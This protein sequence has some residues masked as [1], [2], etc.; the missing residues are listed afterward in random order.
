MAIDGLVDITKMQ[1]NQP[2]EAI[3][4]A[5]VVAQTTPLPPIQPAQQNPAPTDGPTPVVPAPGA[6]DLPST[7]TPNDKTTPAG[8]QQEPGTEKKPASPAGDPATVDPPAEVPVT[9]AVPAGVVDPV[10]GSETPEQYKTRLTAEAAVNAK[11]AAEAEFLKRF[12]VESVEELDNKVNTPAALTDEQKKR[13]TDLHRNEVMNYAVKE[14]AYSPDD[15]TKINRLEQMSDNDLVFERFNQQWLIDNKENPLFT[16]KDL[17]AEARYEFESLF[18]LKAENER[19]RQTGEQSLKLTAD[20]IRNEAKGMWEAAELGYQNYQQ[21]R[22]DVSQFKKEVQTSINTSLPKEMEFKLAD[23]NTAKFQ[24]DKID[25]KGLE[26][27]LRK[28]PNFDAFIKAGKKD[29][30]PFLNSKIQ[31]YIAINHYKDMIATV[32]KTSHD[33]GFNKGTAGARAPFTTTQPQPVT[34]STS[35]LSAAEMQKIADITRLR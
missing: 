15:F 32:D 33:A 24:L 19:M 26:D 1:S 3:A 8:E 28:S 14:L 12:G 29:F 2:T 6:A 30:Q 11:A 18:H 23:G 25:K 34:V 7:T 27:Y 22:S 35:D 21:V 13:Q 5:I 4:P 16:G 20:Q 31:E 17:V 9:P 10:F